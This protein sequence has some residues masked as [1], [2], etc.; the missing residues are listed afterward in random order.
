MQVHRELPEIRKR[1]AEL[2]LVGN[3]N[4]RFGQA[5]K[6]ELKIV[7]PLFVDTKL[8]AY[9]A[10]QMKRGLAA[11]LGSL[12][13]WKNVARAMKAGFRQGS[14]QGDAWQLGGVLVVLPRGQVAFRH[15]SEAAGDHPPVEAV[16]GSL[17]RR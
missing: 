16:L 3:G 14:T 10:L 12:A 8:E 7:C 2:H 5:F 4:R 13:S 1:G 6:E 17:P 15:T 11:T 9:R